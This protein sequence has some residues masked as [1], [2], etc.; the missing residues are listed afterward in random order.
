M[1][2]ASIQKADPSGTPEELLN[3]NDDGGGGSSSNFQFNSIRFT[4]VKLLA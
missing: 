3:V 1:S 4:V 2:S